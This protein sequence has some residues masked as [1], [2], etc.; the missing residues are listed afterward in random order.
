MDRFVCWWYWGHQQPPWHALVLQIHSQYWYYMHVPILTIK[1]TLYY[2]Y[3][4]L[5]NHL[6]FNRLYWNIQTWSLLFL[7]RSMMHLLYVAMAEASYLLSLG[8]NILN[9]SMPSK[10]N[11]SRKSLRVLKTIKILWFNDLNRYISIVTKI[12]RLDFVCK[13][14]LSHALQNHVDTVYLEMTPGTWRPY[15]IICHSDG[16][17]VCVHVSNEMLYF[18]L[19]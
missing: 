9:H 14:R 2:M 4:A 10:I 3:I 11:W 8:K 5:R 17:Q 12:I 7:N 6:C 16:Y 15:G 13:K 18:V 19:L 1:I